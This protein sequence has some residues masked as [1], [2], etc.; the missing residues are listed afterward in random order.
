MMARAKRDLA[1]FARHP[2]QII[3]RVTDVG[4]ARAAHAAVADQFDVFGG[5]D[6]QLVIEPGLAEFVDDHTGALAAGPAQE[7][8]HQRGL[9]AAEKSGHDE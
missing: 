2:H 9:A 3:Q 6:H 5:V 8:L 7:T 1:G 4:P